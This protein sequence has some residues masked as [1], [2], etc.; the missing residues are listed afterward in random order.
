MTTPRSLFV[1]VLLG[2]AAL[3][4]GC[5]SGTT[6]EALIGTW[7]R[8]RDDATMRDRYTFGRDGAFAFDEFKPDDPSLEDHLSGTYE[9]SGD[10]VVA[11]VTNA[12]DAVRARLTFSYYADA[13]SFSSAALRPTGAHDGVVGVWRGLAKLEFLDEPGRAPDGALEVDTFRADGTFSA[14]SSA[15][16]GSAPQVWEGTYA[17]ESPGVFSAT[18]SADSGASR[19]VTW[20]L[21]DDAALVR[22]DRLWLRD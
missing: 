1:R 11:T 22:P 20:E 17:E 4:A 13:T 5:G 16:D 15:P 6:D 3:S 10:T 2:V 9:A 7:S 8:L 18:A 12:P 14:T 21:L 19:T